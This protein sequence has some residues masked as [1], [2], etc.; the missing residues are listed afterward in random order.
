MQHNP[1]SADDEDIQVAY[2]TLTP[3]QRTSTPFVTP[4]HDSESEQP[5]PIRASL[6]AWPR[7]YH[8]LLNAAFLGAVLALGMLLG[9][10][11]SGPY[12][13]LRSRSMP[14]HSSLQV[15]PTRV[16]AT[17]LSGVPVTATRLDARFAIVTLGIQCLRAACDGSWYVV[18][19][20]Q[21]IYALQAGTSC[22][23][24]TPVEVVGG[25]LHYVYCRLDQPNVYTSSFD[26]AQFLCI[27]S[28]LGCHFVLR[29]EM[30]NGR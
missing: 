19:A 30:T 1:S 26:G 20:G 2:S 17:V 14:S 27:G 16:P 11:M 4:P 3:R 22:T 9:T 24:T 23:T 5:G 12:A 28:R 6:G 8:R 29:V 25:G 18:P 13:S 10:V 7:T 15:L 21:E